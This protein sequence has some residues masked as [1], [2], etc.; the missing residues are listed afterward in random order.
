[1]LPAAPN[2]GYADR[3]G[4]AAGGVKPSR[5][6]DS[7]SSPRT[8]PRSSGVFRPIGWK[9]EHA[10]TAEKKRVGARC[11]RSTWLHLPAARR[12]ET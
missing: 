7:R 5:G 6:R 8:A 3:S 1:M 4:F 9:I 2:P 10:R 11:R 12:R